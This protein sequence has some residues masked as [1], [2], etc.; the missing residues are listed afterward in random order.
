[1][2]EPELYICR[3]KLNV[4]LEAH[5]FPMSVL[6]TSGATEECLKHASKAVT[7][8]KSVLRITKEGYQYT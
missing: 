2:P 4:L 1:M 8:V 7:V 6:T 5:S 3:Q